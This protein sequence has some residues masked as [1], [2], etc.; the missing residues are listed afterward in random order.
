MGALIMLKLVYSRSSG[1]KLDAKTST[2][3]ITFTRRYLDNNRITYEVSGPCI[4][5]EVM[6]RE[7]PVP[8]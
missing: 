3:N 2:K 5:R 1:A 7:F 8:H 6:L 4:L